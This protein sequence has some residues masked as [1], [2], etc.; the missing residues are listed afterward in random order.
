MQK[1]LKILERPIQDEI[2]HAFGICFKD[3][4]ITKTFRVYDLSIYLS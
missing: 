4:H 1:T 2:M 3:N